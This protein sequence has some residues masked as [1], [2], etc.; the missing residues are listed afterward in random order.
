MSASMPVLSADAAQGRVARDR[1]AVRSRPRIRQPQVKGADTMRRTDVLLAGVIALVVGALALA[2]QRRL[3]PGEYEQTIEMSRAGEAMPAIKVR[4]CITQQTLDNLTGLLGDAASDEDCKISNQKT[5]ADRIT[6][7][8]TCKDDGEVYE[9]AADLRFA[10]D[11]YSGV[12][13]TK[14]D[15]EVVVTKLTGKRIGACVKD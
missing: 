9:S 12:V 8:M 15:G 10:T 14:T 7:V 11:A 13:T 1:A 5:I 2:A 4:E 6:F 3:Q